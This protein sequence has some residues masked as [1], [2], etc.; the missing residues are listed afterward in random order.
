MIHPSTM[1]GPNLFASGLGTN[2]FQPGISPF[3][4]STAFP[5]GGFGFGPTP[6]PGQPFGFGGQTTQ[7]TISEIVRQTVPQALASCGLLPGGITQSAFGFPGTTGFQTPFG[8]TQ[9][10]PQLPF[11]GFDPQSSLQTPGLISEIAR[12]TA[13]LALQNLGQ[14]YP[15]LLS[16]GLTGQFQP[17]FGQGTTPWGTPQGFG[18]NF[19]QQNLPNAIAQC[20]QAA[21]S[22]VTSCLAQFCQTQG[23]PLNPNLVTQCCQVVTSCVA[24]CLLQLC[25]AQS[26]P[27]SLNNT[28]QFGIS[29]GIPA[30]VGAF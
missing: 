28:S 27:F 7:N 13:T 23:V 12:Q 6:F 25:Q 14:Q 18:T 15:A 4:R 22:C 17:G 19:Q 2:P 30:G 11:G 24:S 21:A 16:Q 9:F 20:C 10:G 5:G 26:A 29:S 8:P 1:A 3:L